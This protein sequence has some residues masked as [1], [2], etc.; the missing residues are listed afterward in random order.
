MIYF[1]SVI[2]TDNANASY[3]NGVLAL[4]LNKKEKPKAKEIKIE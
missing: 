3:K 4:E 2:D 1:D